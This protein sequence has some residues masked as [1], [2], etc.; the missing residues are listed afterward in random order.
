M[1]GGTSHQFSIVPY[2]PWH[3]REIA[4]Q[5]HQEH[6]G[7]F[8]AQ[9][10]FAKRLLISGPCWTAL[11]HG[12]PIA[13]AGFQEQWVGRS[14]CWAI[15]S[16]E[17]GRHMLRLTRAVEKAI[18]DHPAE[19][20]ETTVVE[21]FHAGFRWAKALGFSD[22]GIRRRYHYGQDHR[23]FVLLKPTL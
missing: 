7:A 15:L 22:E 11:V 5:P 13:C 20:I 21:G 19:R 6:L 18:W 16:D 9:A 1:D 12:Q 23:A 10:D 4:L 14:S 8:L 2:E 17:A 3:L